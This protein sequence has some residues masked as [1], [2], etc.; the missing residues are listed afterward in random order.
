M[1]NT[2]L[3]FGSGTGVVTVPN[4]AAFQGLTAFTVE[5]YLSLTSTTHG[6]Y[7]RIIGY[8]S[9]NYGY[10]IFWDGTSQALGVT[11]GNGSTRKDW[12]FWTTL[13]QATT[14]HVALTWNGS[15][16]NMF[17][18][19][20]KDG[21]QTGL[22][23]GNTGNP[24]VD[25]TMCGASSNLILDDVRISNIARYSATFTPPTAPLAS[26][27]NTLDLWNLDEGTGTTTTGVNGNVGTL[28]GTPTPSWVSGL[29]VEPSSFVPRSML[30][31]AG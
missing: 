1:A 31:G 20:V 22:S 12:N 11:V 8:D 18:A 7:A 6:S 17:F 23:G 28:S 3:S 21:S 9:G 14:T 29:S 26:D 15:T 5:F 30:M 2:A 27:A 13:S 25:L 4:A 19:G 16:L 24:A 10:S